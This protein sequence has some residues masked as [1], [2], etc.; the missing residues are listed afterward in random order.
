VYTTDFKREVERWKN[1]EITATE[2]MEN[3]KIKRTSFYKLVKEYEVNCQK[4]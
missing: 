3:A 1:G 4:A 2:A